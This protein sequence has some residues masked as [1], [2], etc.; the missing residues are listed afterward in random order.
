MGEW[1]VQKH[2]KQIRMEILLFAYISN[3]IAQIQQ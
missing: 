2:G 3:S 1:W